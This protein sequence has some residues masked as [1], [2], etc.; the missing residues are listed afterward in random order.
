MRYV[1]VRPSR[2]FL[3][4]ILA[5]QFAPF[6][7][8][9]P[10]QKNA[11]VIELP[12]TRL[13]GRVQLPNQWSLRP[14]G[15]QVMLGDFPVN[16]ALHPQGQWAAV[17]HAG[18][19]TH[20]VVLLDLADDARV[21]SRHVI[22]AAFYGLAWSA[23]G[24]RLYASG[25]TRERV[26]VFRF[27]HE[28][29]VHDAPLPV[30]AQD[31]T[32]VPAGLAVAH[33]GQ[34][35]YV[36]GQR[37]HEVVAV[38]TDTGAALH[39][40]LPDDS[41][42][43]ACIVD[44]AHQRLYVSLWGQASVAVLPLP[45]AAGTPVATFWSTEE[46]P[47]EMLLTRD[48]GTLYVANANR[49]TVSVIDTATGRTRA[50][51]CSA[52][53]PNA[54]A[55]STPNAIA[56]APDEKTLYIAN[57]DNNNVA[58]MDVSDP[59]GGRSLGFIPVGWYPTSVR[60]TPDG[61]RL[62]V[63]NGKGITSK[64]NRHGPQPER[65]HAT[66]VEYIAGLLQGTLSVINVPKPDALAKLSEQAY[67]CSPLRNDL[68]PVLTRPDN[69]PIPAAPGQPSPIKY[70]LYIVKE[71]RTY[72]QVLGDMP[73]GNG[74]PTL[75]IFPENVTPNLHAIARE[76]VLLDNFYVE[77][78]VSADG[79][80]WSM[81]AYATDFVEKNW[82]LNYGGKS[83][84]KIGYPSEG[85][86]RIATPASGYIWDR[87]AAANVTYR[88]YG[89]FVRR[90]GKTLQATSPALEGHFDPEYEPYNLDYSD[91]DRAAR[92]IDELHRFE[93]AGDMPQMQ[94]LRLP[95]DHTHGT[96]AGKL[97]PTAMVAQ[98]D[99]AM[100]RVVEALSRS[101]FWPQ[102]AVFVV[103]D[104]AQ[105]GPD[106]VDAHRTTAYVISPYVRRGTVDH[107]LY[108]TSSMLRTMELILGLAPMTQFD[109]AARPMYATFGP[110]ANTRPYTARA[111]QADLEAK[112]A[113]VAWGAEESAEM[114]L[115]VEDAA[116]DLRFNE[117][118]WRSVRGADS[119]MPAPVRAAF[120][121]A[122]RDDDEPDE[123]DD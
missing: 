7:C 45:L 123:D 110:H 41:Y 117:I 89:E 9:A 44:E 65:R 68:Q 42:P 64:A 20:E 80:E 57:A 13:D 83:F 48:G 61:K 3:V 113:A 56:L 102:M 82:P 38:R 49:N 17:L 25:A 2:L 88:S 21:V 50:V 8:V 47:N 81:A 114:N 78:E 22:D 93:A 99:L 87:C 31:A 70:V 6:G 4:G 77:S 26:E 119:P 59:S 14:T 32:C 91:L 72:D 52:I 105:N 37:G 35:V 30:A 108:S 103:E 27:E 66:T 100:G 116:D 60:V 98:N 19:G 111:P 24:T 63:A 46:H 90:D 18:Y 62:L 1:R 118:I 109:A 16:I 112:N 5:A 55:G 54:P 95:N 107:T 121:I 115:A 106:H 97:T 69:N 53:Y 36:A 23:D 73:E 15:R 12:G 94:I 122:G 74:D 104:D 75:C 96:R 85:E 67:A 29:L 39:V 58:V 120:V 43:Y 40:K 33:D 51:L 79:H 11:P 28:Q 10:Q 101:R 84:G 86:A 71:N 76:F 34:T 92:F